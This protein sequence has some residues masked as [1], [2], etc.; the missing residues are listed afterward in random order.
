MKVNFSL[1]GDGSYISVWLCIMLKIYKYKSISLSKY[2]SEK[3]YK[4]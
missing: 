1:N 3:F 2:H 4:K